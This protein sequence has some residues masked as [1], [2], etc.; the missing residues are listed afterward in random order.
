MMRR[1]QINMNQ[2][3][4]ERLF[5][6]YYRPVSQYFARRGCSKEEC[7]D[8]AQETF[9]SAYRGM[10]SYRSESSL[11]TWLFVIAA[12][13]W[14][15]WLRSQKAQ[16]RSAT[17]VSLEKESRSTERGVLNVVPAPDT[18]A[19]EGLLSSERFALLKR[20]LENLP[21]RMRFCFL[22]RFHQGLKYREIANV[23]GVSV[24]TV[25]SQLFQARG[26]LKETVGEHFA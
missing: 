13:V 19:L 18:S 25:K 6:D 3:Q 1:R 22:L 23:M 17:E 11:E 2:G 15:N 4:F 9:M 10:S 12:N 7:Q 5:E 16:K 14:R 21:A 24:E 8:L 20:E 26:R